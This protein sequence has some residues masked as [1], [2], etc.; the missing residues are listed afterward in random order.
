[1]SDLRETKAEGMKEIIRLYVIKR[2]DEN[3]A[4][5]KEWDTP[6]HEG[7]VVT[8]TLDSLARYIREKAREMPADHGC[9]AVEDKV[10]FG[11][12]NHFLEEEARNEIKVPATSDE[13]EPKPTAKVE[14][15]PK[16]KPT[17]APTPKKAKKK[18]EEQGTQLALFSVL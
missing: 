17:P 2:F 6:I 9:V 8:R 3:P 5:E 4:L 12:I 10:V 1:M 14:E 11:W 13:E 7:G 18:V 15:A 16:P